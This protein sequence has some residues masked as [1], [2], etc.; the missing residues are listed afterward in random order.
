LLHVGE[1][2]TSELTNAK[3]GGI[4]KFEKRSVAAEK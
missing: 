1:I 2:E 4:Q 3:S